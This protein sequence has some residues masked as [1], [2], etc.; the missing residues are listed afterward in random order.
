[1]K[2]STVAWTVVLCIASACL[3]AALIRPNLSAPA[4]TTPC[5]RPPAPRQEP[6]ILNAEPAG[7]KSPFL[8]PHYYREVEP[9]EQKDRTTRL[10]ASQAAR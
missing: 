2:R 10:T 9:G 4:N 5:D 8:L 1:M 7:W 3:G 6:T